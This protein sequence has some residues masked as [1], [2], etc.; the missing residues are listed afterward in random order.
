MRG[1]GS[2]AA[3]GNSQVRGSVHILEDEGDGARVEG[4]HRLE[5]AVLRAQDGEQL[6]AGD[7]PACG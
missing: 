2:E 7:V 3:Q 4:R 6:A 5:E 1:F